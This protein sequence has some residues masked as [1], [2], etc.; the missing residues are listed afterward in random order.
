[1]SGIKMDPRLITFTNKNSLIA[2]QY[3]N[4]RAKISLATESSAGKTILVT[5]AVPGEGKSLTSTNMAITIAQGVQETVL[6]V[7]ADLRHPSLHVLFGIHP[8]KG[9]TDYLKNDISLESIS[10]ATPVDGLSFIPAGNPV[11]NP[12][13]LLASQ[14][15]KDLVQELKTRY[16]NKFIIFDSPPVIPTSDPIILARMLDWTI[17]VILAGKTPRETV[18]RA[19][20]IY[21]LKNIL[22]IVLNNLETMPLEYSYGYKQKRYYNPD[23]K[24]SK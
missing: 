15:M 17:F 23:Y 10:L 12:S 24:P 20:G 19:I 16:S 8:E 4:L 3:R 21:E 5:S 18:A 2:E 9:L 14:K 22:G 7:D 1:M 6:L 11:S 13:E